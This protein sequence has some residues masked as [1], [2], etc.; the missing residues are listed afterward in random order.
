MSHLLEEYAKN[1]GVKVSKP[2]VQEHFFPLLD[3]K[4]IILCGEDETQ[5]KYYKHYVLVLSLLKPILKKNNIKVYQFGGKRI[6]GVSKLLDLDFKKFAYIIS[7]SL[8][9]VGPDNHLAQYASSKDI[10]TI[11]IYGNCYSENTKPFWS[12]GE[13][14]HVAIE[15]KWDK[16][17]CF[18]P[19]DIKEQINTINPEDICS[20]ILDLCGLEGEEIEFE[21]K[22]MG[23][24]FYQNITEVVPTE[25]SKLDI[26]KDI[27]LRV[28]YGF[29]ESSFMHY[30]LNHKVTIVTDK[31]IQPNILCKLSGNVSK[32]LYTINKELETIPQKYFDILKSM[33][34]QITLLSEKEEDLN[35]LRNKYFEIPVQLRKKEKEKI[36]C[37]PESRF[38]SNKNIIEGDKVYKSYAHYKK[39]LDSNHNVLDTSEYWEEQEHFC[40]YEQKESSKKSEG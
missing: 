8:L 6:S 18:A 34:I 36:K 26:P 13:S 29:E 23:K 19:T 3:D 12:S 4:Y 38:L 9:Y 37:S 20:H 31:L 17:P 2:I 33:G 25:I 5:S 7:K 15:P 27:F 32:I 40:I 10:N 16:K 30:C 21:T 22:H 28:D 1:L 14:K 11:T 35:Y 39:G 24:H